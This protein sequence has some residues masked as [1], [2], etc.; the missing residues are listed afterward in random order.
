MSDL[1]KR[2][3]LNRI[4]SHPSGRIL[5]VAVDHLINYPTGL[6]QGLRTMDHTLREIV[7]GRPSA[8]TMNKGIATRYGGLFAGITPLIVQSMALRPEEPDFADTATVEEVVALGADAIAV[9][10]FVHGPFEIRY[11]RH[12]SAV[13]REAERYGMPVIPHIYPLTSGDERHAVA[14]DAEAVFYAVRAGLEMGADVIKVPYT[15][16]PASFRDITAVTPVPVVCAGGPRCDTLD[17]ADRMV[18]AVVAAGAAGATVGRNV[19]GFADI[20]AAI[21]RLKAAAQGG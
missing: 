21:A 17:E 3:R 16:D 19:W 11:L 12:L 15:G 4:F 8:L 5:S 1:G 18:R 2:I 10:M 20:P 6:P 9:S 7:R 13:V 14:H